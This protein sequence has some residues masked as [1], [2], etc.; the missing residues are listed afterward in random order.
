MPSVSISFQG[1]DDERT[2]LTTIYNP[3]ILPV[4]VQRQIARFGLVGRRGDNPTVSGLLKSSR[5]AFTEMI[6][7]YGLDV[8]V[9]PHKA[10]A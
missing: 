7:T 1:D 2:L 8:Q 6:M 9:V 5:S 4:G 10:S 3:E